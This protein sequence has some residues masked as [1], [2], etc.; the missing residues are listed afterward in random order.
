STTDGEPD[1]TIVFVV[2]GTTD[3]GVRAALRALR[4]GSCQF[5]LACAVDRDGQV[6]R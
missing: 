2:T 3:D 1:S 5:Y 6:M 4:A